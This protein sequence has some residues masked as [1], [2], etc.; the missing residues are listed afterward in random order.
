MKT[1]PLTQNKVALVDDSDYEWASQ[2]SWHAAKRGRR[3]YAARKDGWKG[4]SYYMHRELAGVATL[5]VDHEDGDGLNNQR[6]NLKPRTRR[7]N[8]CGFSRP[9]SD[10]TS[11]FVGVCRYREKWLA[12]IREDGKNRILGRFDSEEE[13]GDAYQLAKHLRNLKLG[14]K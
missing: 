6:H 2:F 7:Q 9:H 12:Q 11:R 13:A 14:M 1:I 8:L 4:K 5:D 3:W 10:K